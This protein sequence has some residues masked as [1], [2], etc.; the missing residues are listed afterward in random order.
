MKDVTYKLKDAFALSLELEFSLD[1]ESDELDLFFFFF[2]FFAFL[3]FFDPLPF[4]SFTSDNPN[5]SSL[6]AESAAL[7]KWA[8]TKSSVSCSASS[9]Q[10]RYWRV[11]LV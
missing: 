7:N 8:V 10:T 3:F 2:A 9:S 1:V 4:P 11:S 5:W 6:S